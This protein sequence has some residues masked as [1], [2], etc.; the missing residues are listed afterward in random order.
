MD[1]VLAQQLLS[2]LK[3]LAGPG[4]L[5]PKQLKY[6]YSPCSST[7]PKTYKTGGYDAFFHPLL[8]SVMTW[9]E[10][11]MLTKLLKLKTSVLLGLETK[12]AYEFILYCY[13][14]LYKLGIIHQ[15]GVEFDSYQLQ[16]KAKQWWRAYMEC[17]YS[18]LPPLT[19]TQFHAP[20]LEKYVPR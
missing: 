16:G 14:R 13:N 5:P 17:T 18:T 11:D 3:G 1:L 19:W 2:F 7:A 10:H 9:N 8:G 6:C 20:F 15:H 4:M 12:D